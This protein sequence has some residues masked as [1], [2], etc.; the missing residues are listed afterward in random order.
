VSEGS[1]H[2][3]ADINQRIDLA[4]RRAQVSLQD[5][6]IVTAAS[7]SEVRVQLALATN[8]ACE[9]LAQGE[10]NRAANRINSALRDDRAIEFASDGEF[11]T[12]WFVCDTHDDLL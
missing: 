10:A 12:A 6:G 3:S 2:A 5:L 9:L 8:P 7:G 11:L 1:C 4:S